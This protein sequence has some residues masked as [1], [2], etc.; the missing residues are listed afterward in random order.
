MLLKTKYVFSLKNYA[1]VSTND[2]V[3]IFGGYD[4]ATLGGEVDVVAQ[5]KETSFYTP[6]AFFCTIDL[7]I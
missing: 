4:S 2:H 1:Q 3:I 5:F 6:H 7:K